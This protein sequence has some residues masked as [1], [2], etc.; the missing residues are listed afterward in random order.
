[1][2]TVLECL[3][4]AWSPI[5]TLLFLNA[6]GEA[7]GDKERKRPLSIAEQGNFFVGGTYNA[8]DQITGQMYVEYQVPQGRK[9]RHPIVFVQ[10]GAQMGQA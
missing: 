2:Q 5:L 7:V 9:H 1:M 10:G 4:K 8:D 6:M 3:K